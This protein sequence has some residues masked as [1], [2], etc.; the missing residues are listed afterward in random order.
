MTASTNTSPTNHPPVLMTRR[1]L[2]E[3][4]HISTRS[5][6]R[7]RAGGD[8]LDPLPGAGCPRWHPAEV[9]AWVAAGGPRAE[10]WRRL[11]RRRP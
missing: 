1:D 4:L 9:A 10:V 6:D 3:V 8:I 7:M 11:H 5:L 2:A